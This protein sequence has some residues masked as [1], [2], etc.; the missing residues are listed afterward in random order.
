MTSNSNIRVAFYGCGNFAKTT[1]IPNLLQIDN[2]NIIAACD[3]NK[4]ILEETADQF[5]IPQVYHPGN[6]GGTHYAYH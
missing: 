1:R 5:N 6:G 2:V 3:I 4:Q